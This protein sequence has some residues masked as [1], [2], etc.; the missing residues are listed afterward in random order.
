MRSLHLRKEQVWG[1]QQHRWASWVRASGQDLMEE[2]VA[3]V[4]VRVG[5]GRL[6]PQL[7]PLPPGSRYFTEE[8]G[9]KEENERNT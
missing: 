9:T 6:L 7:Q 3:N 2:A 1:E 8:L 4:R 5:T